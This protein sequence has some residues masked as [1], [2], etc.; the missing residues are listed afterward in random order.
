MYKVFINHKEIILTS[1]N[2]NGKLG[3]VLPLKS[4]SFN[5]IIRIIRTTR[6][7]RLYLIHDNPKKILIDFKKKLP[8]IIAAGGV[9]QHENG[10]LLFIYRKKKWDL[11]KGKVDKDESL[12]DAAKREVREE[13]GI[14]KIKVG[15]LAGITYHIFKRNN[16]YQLK[17]SHWFYM[18]SSY[19][20][21]LVPEFKEHITKATWK[22]KNK[23]VKAIKKTYPN[24]KDLFD[25]SNLMIAL[26]GEE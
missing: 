1:T 21:T 3:K 7:K 23:T 14:K 13:T 24:I 17:E 4:T 6:V 19:G 18:K 2:P 26:F 12:E 16:C 25:Q 22:N 9:L 5:T 15:K 8:V 20:G 10:K 11:P